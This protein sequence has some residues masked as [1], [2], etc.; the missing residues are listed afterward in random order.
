[1]TLLADLHAH[2]EFFGQGPESTFSEDALNARYGE[3]AGRKAIADGTLTHRRTMFGVVDARC[4]CWLSDKGA[5]AAK[6]EI[7]DCSKA[8]DMLHPSI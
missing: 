5:I 3:D 6:A 4:L 2:Q 1:M 7:D 8:P